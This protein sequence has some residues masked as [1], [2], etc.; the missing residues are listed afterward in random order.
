MCAT[1]I[2]QRR[3]PKRRSC[4]AVHLRAERRFVRARNYDA[5]GNT[6]TAVD[7]L[8]RTTSNA[9]DQRGLRV[10]VTEAVGTAQ[11]RRTTT[12]YDAAANVLS[13]TD[14]LT[15]VTSFAYDALNR[16]I[17]VL[18]AYGTSVQRATTAVYDLAG[19]VLSSIDARGVTASFGY[20]AL[21]RQVQRIEAY[22]TAVQRTTTTAY[23]P[24]GNVLAVT[25]PRGTVSSYGY[26]ADNRQT[27]RLDAY[28]TSL[29]RTTTTAYDPVGN[30]LSTDNPVNA[31]T[32][33]AYDALNRQTAL[34]EA[35]GSAVQRTTTTSYDPV[36]NVLFTTNPRGY[37]T[38]YAYDA[39]NRGILELD[40]YGTSLQRALTTV[41][42]AVSNV[43][44][45]ANGLN[46]LTSFGYDALNRRTT[47]LDAYGTALQ[48][49]VTTVYDLDD[50]VTARIDAL[51]YP[52]TFVFDA[53]NRQIAVQDAGGGIATM[54][55]DPNNN[56]VNT[57]D[58]LG[59]TTTQ[60][61][62]SLNRRTQS[63]DAL[64]GTVTLSYD[65]NDNLVALTDP[66]NNQTQWQYDALDRKV[67]ETD[68]LFNSATQA[69][70]AADRMTSTTDRNGQ[71][72]AYSYDPLNR[73]TGET[74][75]TSSGTQVNALTFSYDA[76]NNLL[77]AANNTATNTMSYDALDRLS[78]MQVPFGAVL[79]NSYDPADNRTL[80]QDSFGGVTTRTYDALNRLTTIQFGGSGQTPLRE[81][82]TYTARDQVASQARYSDLAGSNLIGS[83]ALTYDAVARLTNL[84]HEDGTGANLANYTNSYDVASRIT[85]EV[86]DGGTPTSYAYDATN[87]L[88][89]DGVATYT[90]DLNGNRTMTGYATGP[91]NEMTSDGTWSY[92]YDRNG[93]VVAKTNPSTGEAWAFSYDNRNRLAAA[94]QVTTGVQMQATYV[95][96]PQ[97][98]RIEKDVWTQSSGTTTTRFA[99][100]GREI[101]ADLTSGD[102]LQTRY[103]RG[104][105]VLELLARIAS[106][107][108][109]AWM[110]ADRMGSVRN[111]VDN[112]G[113]VI[114]TI[115]YDAYGNVT[116][117][118]S[119]PNGGNYQAFG[120]RYD[121]ETGFMRPDSST[122]RY[123]HS[124]IGRWMVRDPRAARGDDSNLYRYVRNNPMS[125]VDPSGEKCERLD[126]KKPDF[127]P[128]T[129]K[130]DGDECEKLKKKVGCKGLKPAPIPDR[131]TNE[132]LLGLTYCAK[133]TVE[134][135]IL[136]EI[137]TNELIDP[138]NDDCYRLCVFK[139]EEYHRKMVRRC[140]PEICKCYPDN[141]YDIDYDDPETTNIW[142]CPATL[143]GLYCLQQVLAEIEKHPTCSKNLIERG[144][145]AMK[146]AYAKQCG[147]LPDTIKPP[148]STPKCRGEK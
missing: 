10:S 74:W 27:Q 97:G 33:H 63:I 103:V 46:V 85:A 71:R 82:M 80:V 105:Q 77:T 145:K 135:K 88:T 106:G 122:V 52:T 123:Y 68:P 78:S 17:A 38:S 138:R 51:G 16:R 64:G 91:A 127:D 146:D 110:L 100:D 19:N 84:Q 1:S 143:A 111:A 137:V 130:K 23:D 20:D 109:P 39:L 114:D 29:Q 62:D 120:Y 26:D 31:T 57:I 18:E 2:C 140:C 96:D 3:W 67:Q 98:Q 50:N 101:W 53:L 83:S 126:E 79:T 8:G 144:L 113:A 81:D 115:T 35:Y 112:T 25:N 93:N 55:Y 117:D 34:I 36:G 9:Y 92:Y 95:Y 102:A 139:H 5:A 30:V 104:L 13:V 134:I 21:N 141:T 89:N 49:T 61:Y 45:V 87:Q 125:H 12:A 11:Q 73:E 142:E 58:P 24:V 6:L 32:S 69:Y 42:D 86:L 65:A 72:I 43:L 66:V 99:Y 107:G 121:G 70:D 48:R 7:E 124:V 108:T 14:P 59:H 148:P 4:G 119:P 133:G 76:N 54:V 28:G 22:G 44:S 37:T 56:V 47:E 129:W 60:V 90:Y 40:A 75:Y 116:N 131:K 128:K 136:D 94:Q 15:D 41:Y 147:K 118:T 132:G